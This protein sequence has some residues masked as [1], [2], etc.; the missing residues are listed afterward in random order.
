MTEETS[1]KVVKICVPTCPVFTGPVTYI[2]VKYSI[3]K[4]NFYTV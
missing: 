4:A 1:K 2:V 3:K